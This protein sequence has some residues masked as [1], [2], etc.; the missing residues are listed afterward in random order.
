[1][2]PLLLDPAD[3]LGQ[4]N[5]KLRRIAEVLIARVERERHELI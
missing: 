4:Q 1:M 3:D 2:K 5:A